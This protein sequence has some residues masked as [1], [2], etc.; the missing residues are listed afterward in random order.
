[1][2]GIFVEIDL[3]KSKWLLFATYKPTSSSNDN[4]FFQV[5]KVL[6]A[7]GSKYENT[8]LIGDLNTTDADEKLV[9]FLEDR[10]LSNLVHFPTF[11]MIETNPSTIDLIITNK[12]KSFQN[13]I[14]VFTGISDFHK[15]V[16]TSMKTTFPKAVPKEITY[17]DMKNL[18]KKPLNVILKTI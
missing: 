16:L 8:V 15:M 9:E 13:T 18:D 7:H 4:Y 1:M 6:D 3:R 2:E 17:R 5:N 14:G 10:K 11:F 12:P